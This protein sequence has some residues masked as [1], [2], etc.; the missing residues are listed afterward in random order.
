[1]NLQEK[2]KSAVRHLRRIKNY[3]YAKLVSDASYQSHYKKIK[4]VIGT[5][6]RDEK[7]EIA[8][9]VHLFYTEAWEQISN[10]IK[11][12]SEFQ[13]D[14]F[15]SL[16]PEKM[17]YSEKIISDFPQAYIYESPN[18]G[19]DVLPFMA[20]VASLRSAGYKY[21]LKLHSKKSTHRKDGQDWFKQITDNLM[22]SDAEIQRSVFETLQ[23]SKTAII[24][25]AKNYTSLIVNFEANGEHMTEVVRKIYG[26]NIA[27]TV[28]QTNRKEY[29]FFAGTMLWVRLDSI[30]P[31]LNIGKVRRFE[32]EKGQIDATYAHALERLMCV[33]PEIEKQRIYEV[34]NNGVREI[35]YSDGIIP[36]WSEVYIGPKPA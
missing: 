10:R 3:S 15:V 23:E 35:G 11:L 4:R 18:Q 28:L 14:I 29:G 32:T 30:A 1:M 9:V 5:R 36:D 20:I 12:I 8:I 16:P 7:T 25:P 13:Y 34:D 17:A 19:R 21:V 6:A 31:L 27:R 24:G 33:V 2:S 26:K 22:P